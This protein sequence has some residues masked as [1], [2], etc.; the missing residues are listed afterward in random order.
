MTDTC[1]HYFLLARRK[2]SRELIFLCNF[3][4]LRLH[5][6]GLSGFRKEYQLSYLTASL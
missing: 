6:G 5:A 4:S 3:P 2:R 1:K